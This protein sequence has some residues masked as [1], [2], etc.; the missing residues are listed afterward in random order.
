MAGILMF[1]KYD[2]IT[3]NSGDPM[4]FVDYRERIA[5]DNP[6]IRWTN[7]IY[8]DGLWEANLY[9]FYIR[10]YNRLIQS[11]PR[12][13]MMKDGVRALM[14]LRC[15]TAA[16]SAACC[17][18]PA[19]QHGKGRLAAVHHVG[20]VA[21]DG[22]CMGAHGTGRHMQYAGQPLAG[23]TVHGGDH[24]HKALRGGEAGGQRAGLQCAVTCAAGTGLGLAS[25]P[26]V[27]AGRRCSSSPWQTTHRRARP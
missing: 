27:P 6:D 25:P 15:A 16:R 13:F 26:V 11:L 3:N 12:P 5:T 14:A 22:E 2:S 1:G 10:V 21:E 4:Y 24:Q 18:L 9:Q 20:V 8:P 7:R 23:D 17:T 19:G